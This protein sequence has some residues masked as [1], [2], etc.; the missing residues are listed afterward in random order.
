MRIAPG[1]PTAGADGRRQR[2]ARLVL[3]RRALVRPGAAVAHGASWSP[4]EPTSSTS[5][6]SR[7]GPVP[8]GP[9]VAEEPAG[10]LPVIEALAADGCPSRSTPCAPRSPS[11]RSRPGGGIVNDVSGGL[12]DADA[13]GGRG[14]EATYVAMHWRAHS[15]TCSGFA[16]YD[17]EDGVVAR[18]ATSWP[19]GSRRSRRR[20]STRSRSCSTRARLRQA[21]EHNWALLRG[22]DVLRPRLPGAG[23]RQPQVVPRGGCWVGAGG[24]RP[25]DRDAATTALTTWLALRHPSVWGVRVHDVRVAARRAGGAGPR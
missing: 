16:T 21:A 3:R 25:P 24:L 1:V 23:R 12:A 10:S 4:T 17:P 20:A 22:L 11:A 19:S 8:P 7:P 18:C 2:H 9:L 13:R 14:A 5:A 15:D 6:A